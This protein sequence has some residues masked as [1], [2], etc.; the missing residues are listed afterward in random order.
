LCSASKLNTK[1]SFAMVDR[2]ITRDDRL[3]QPRGHTARTEARWEGWGLFT[4]IFLPGE[5]VALI[6]HFLM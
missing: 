2:D 3:L 1:R 6:T 4:A 5:L